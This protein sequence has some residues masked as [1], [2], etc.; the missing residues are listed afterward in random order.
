[1]L[2][3][4]FKMAIVAFG[5][6]LLVLL[7]INP[8]FFSTSITNGFLLFLTSYA[9]ISFPFFF[10]SKLLSTFDFSCKKFNLNKIYIVLFLSFISGYPNNAKMVSDLYSKNEISL[11]QAKYLLSLT[12]ISSPVFVIY[13]VGCKFLNNINSGYIIYISL[14][15][16]CIINSFLYLKKDTFLSINNAEKIAHFSLL[17][18]MKDSLIS[19]CI[20]GGF[21]CFFYFLIDALIYVKIL[22]QDNIYIIS[23]FEITRGLSIL[24]NMQVTKKIL[25]I[26]AGLIS[27]G[28]VSITVQSIAFLNNAPIKIGYY[29]CSKITQSIITVFVCYILLLI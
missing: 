11:N 14:I 9:P 24:K 29:L 2:K 22:P 15:I 7:F 6:L 4:F 1:M 17:N 20:V 25:P 27:F 8:T 13:S 23:L 12:S 5:I 16:A 26:C 10:I 3:Y 21:I 18:V 19:L 28:G